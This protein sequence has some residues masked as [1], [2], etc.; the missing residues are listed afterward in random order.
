MNADRPV[1]S[2]LR[3]QFQTSSGVIRKVGQSRLKA[4]TSAQDRYLALNS[5]RHRWTTVYQLARELADGGITYTTTIP[6]L[7]RRAGTLEVQSLTDSKYVFGL[8]VPNLTLQKG[9]NTH[10]YATVCMSS[11]RILS[12][13]SAIGMRPLMPMWNCSVRYEPRL[14]FLDDN[15]R[16]FK[17]RI[18]DE[19]Y[20]E[21]YFCRMDCPL[22]SSDRNPFEHVWDGLERAISQ[23]SQPPKTHGS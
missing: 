18:V 9:P 13:H 19:F 12:S 14:H 15:A 7:R 3:N 1:K 23:R 10:R 2:W 11:M 16:S 5:Q 4:K 8:G 21:E 22:R 20:E 17:A 6:V